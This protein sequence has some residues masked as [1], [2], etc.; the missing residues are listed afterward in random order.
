MDKE[1][2]EKTQPVGT[3]EFWSLRPSRSGMQSLFDTKW[4]T[5]ANAKD[6]DRGLGGAANAVLYGVD[7]SATRQ[8]CGWGRFVGL[9]LASDTA[10][11]SFYPV[12]TR[13][14]PRINK[15]LTI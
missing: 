5:E 11:V 12:I 14:Y 8:H 1:Y 6:C 15:C 9:P 3:V 10:L 13:F 7:T 4:K 2:G